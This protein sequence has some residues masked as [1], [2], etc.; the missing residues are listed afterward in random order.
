MTEMPITT[1]RRAPCFSVGALENLRVIDVSKLWA[2]P[3]LTELLANLGAEV[4]KVEAIQS[5]DLWRSGGA[6]LSVDSVGAKPAYE[7]S[8]IFNAVNRNKLGVTLDLTRAEGQ[9]LLKRL[10][11]IG[12]IVV[13][14]YSPR[15]MA[16]F[17]LDYAALSAINDRVIMI[18]LPAYGMTGP[19][20]DFVGFAYPTEESTGFPH[21]TGYE[22]GPPMLWGPAGADS[23]A[24]I[25][26]AVAV[27]A[28]LL[29][30]ERTGTGQYIDLSQVEALT[31]WLGP[32]MID[33][34]WNGTQAKRSG[35]R[36]LQ[37]APHG[38]YRAGGE[39][40][41]VV[42][43]V[44]DDRQWLALCEVLG[45][46]DWA[47]RGDLAEVAGRRE[48]EDEL[49]RGISSWT[50]GLD[51]REAAQ[52]LQHAGVAAAPVL[53]GDELIS[54][55]HLR[56]R[57]FIEWH[58]R[59]WVGSRA[60]TGMWAKLS[61]TP[62]TIRFPAP[63]LGEHNDHVLRGLLGLG[64]DEMADLE[65]RKIIGTAPTVKVAF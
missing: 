8:P 13:E 29:Q 33:Y 23:F 36:D 19:W 12:D 10:V 45:R 22:D 20:R 39:D 50:A 42:V 53:K 63:Q 34:C 55:P 59:A 65:Q 48:L 54:D 44:E 15:V 30:R 16:K 47:A 37:M 57:G 3:S 64:Q 6:R 1:D 26:G 52:I 18:S 58:D 60:H 17:G 31:T 32:Q 38:C 27:S 40:C 51:H 41:W 11:A 9:E 62:G 56:A 2:G 24:G 5:P 49:D 25:T 35:N 14:N 4:I 28:A 61:R 43:A 7:L 21:F 46:A